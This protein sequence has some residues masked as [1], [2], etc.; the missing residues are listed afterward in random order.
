MFRIIQ[1]KVDE[2]LKRGLPVYSFQIESALREMEEMLGLLDDILAIGN[3]SFIAGNSL[4]IADLLFFHET[5]NMLVYSLPFAQY[6][7]LSAWYERVLAVPE[8]KQIHQEF[9]SLIPLLSNTLKKVKIQ[10]H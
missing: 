10:S 4:T 3:C 8:I 1:H 2:G 9:E 7:H 6:K 5:T